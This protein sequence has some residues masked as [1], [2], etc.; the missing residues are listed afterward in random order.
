MGVECDV[1]QLVKFMRNI[2][3]VRQI[4]AHV[5]SREDVEAK[6]MSVPVPESLHFLEQGAMLIEY[7]NDGLKKIISVLN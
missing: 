7:A 1:G 6:R 2:N 5:M 3:D 4:D